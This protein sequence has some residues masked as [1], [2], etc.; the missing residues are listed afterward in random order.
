VCD[1]VTPDSGTLGTICNDVGLA[2]G[3]GG[4]VCKVN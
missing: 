2:G 3:T 4:A 1:D